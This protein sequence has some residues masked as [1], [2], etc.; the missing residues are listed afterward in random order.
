MPCVK[1]G[2]HDNN[3][4]H[5]CVR[6]ELHGGWHLAA[7]SQPITMPMY[8]NALHARRISPP[9]TAAGNAC[10]L[11]QIYFPIRLQNLHKNPTHSDIHGFVRVCSASERALAVA[12]VLGCQTAKWHKSIADGRLRMLKR[13]SMYTGRVTAGLYV[14]IPLFGLPPYEGDKGNQ[15]VGRRRPEDSACLIHKREE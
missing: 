1:N 14:V 8:P 13:V 3:E 4:A 6:P 10:S 2:R 15:A 11:A 12:P 5:A 9:T 7:F